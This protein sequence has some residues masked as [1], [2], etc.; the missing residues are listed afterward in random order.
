MKGRD[1]IED[2]NYYRGV[3]GEIY[4]GKCRSF[5]EL[6]KDYVGKFRI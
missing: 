6:L 1:S 5:K 4:I 2:G 3:R